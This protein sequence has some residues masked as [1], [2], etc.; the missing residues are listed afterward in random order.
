METFFSQLPRR[1]LSC[2]HPAT[3][4]P[5]RKKNTHTH[6][7]SLFGAN[8]DTSQI[9]NS[10]LLYDIYP[11]IPVLHLPH[12]AGPYAPSLSLS[13]PIL[14]PPHSLMSC[15]NVGVRV[16]VWPRAK[17]LHAAPCTPWASKRDP[18]PPSSSSSSL[19]S[20]SPSSASLWGTERDMML[21]HPHAYICIHTHTHTHTRTHT[22][23]HTHRA[24]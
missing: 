6:T 4:V 23:T 19:N 21:L 5:Y 7:H 10:F 11:P 13:L 24:W 22:H 17:L 3:F 9:A 18:T 16:H 14:P 8:Y 15:M 20:S 12:R 1:L 2:C